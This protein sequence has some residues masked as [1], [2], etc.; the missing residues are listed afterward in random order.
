MRC[1]FSESQ[2][3]L[4]SAVGPKPGFVSWLLPSRPGIPALSAALPARALG[5]ASL[6]KDFASSSA[7]FVALQT[8]LSVTLDSTPPGVASPSRRSQCTAPPAPTPCL[9][10]LP[11]ADL[12]FIDAPIP[13]V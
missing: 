11:E 10:L 2:R 13:V 8:G 9:G 12:D 3:A 4:L 6:R 5:R 7:L 1:Q